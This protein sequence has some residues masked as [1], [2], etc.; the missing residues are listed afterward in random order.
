MYTILIS[1]ITKTLKINYKYTVFVND[2]IKDHSVREEDNDRLLNNLPSIIG[3]KRHEK[4]PT[5]HMYDNSCNVI[6]VTSIIAL[7]S[8]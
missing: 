6:N 3:E 2:E 1:I 5:E 4:L 8:M 7:I